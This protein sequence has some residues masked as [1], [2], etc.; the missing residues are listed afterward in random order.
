MQCQTVEQ[1]VVVQQIFSDAIDHK[2]KK[3]MLLV[4]EECHG[5]I[6]DLLLGIL[7][8]RNQVHGL[9]VAEVDVPSQDIDIQQ[10]A[11]IFFLVV[12]AEV[13][14]LELLPDVGQLLVDS[15]FFKL[16]SARISQVGNELDQASHV[17]IAIARAAQEARARGRHLDV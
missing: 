11:D 1:L 7:L 17:G 15:L 2:M 8:R 14:L 6:S 10:L 4:E 12:P 5:Q 13:G 9:E 3:L 16:S